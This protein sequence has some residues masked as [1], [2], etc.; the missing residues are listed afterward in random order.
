MKYF[1]CFEI[2]CHIVAVTNSSDN[3][4]VCD[5][6]YCSNYKCRRQHLLHQ[7]RR[8]ATRPRPPYPTT[9]SGLSD[10]RSNQYSWTRSDC[11]Y[12]LLKQL[13][14]QQ[15]KRDNFILFFFFRS[16][17]FLLTPYIS[18]QTSPLYPRN[19]RYVSHFN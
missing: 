15:V 7:Q 9:L 19:R 13:R 3:L 16:Y 4:T 5:N 12:L 1:H 11:K 18:L 10:L 6:A 2:L 14:L 8:F 17:L